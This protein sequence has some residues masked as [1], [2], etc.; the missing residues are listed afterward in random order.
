MKKMIFIKFG[1]S[2]ITDKNQEEKVNLDSIDNLSKQVSEILNKEKDIK[3]MIGNG[4]GS[5]GHM[6]VERYK[7]NNGVKTSVQ[8]LGVTKVQELVARLNQMVV[9]SLT[10]HN[11]P[12][13]SIKPSSIITT[14]DKKIHNLPMDPLINYLNEKDIKIDK[15]IFCGSTK[16]VL[17]LNGNTIS[18][19]TKKSF[20]NIKNVFFENRY[21]DVTGSMKKKVETA[22]RIT[23]FGIKSYIIDI[24]SLSSCVLDNKFFGT[25]IK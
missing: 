14:S 21:A 3:I 18:E 5:F 20:P 25:V 22:L 12:A 10:K 9:K 15:I 7:L 24:A 8:K 13:V 19:I 23:E 4:A 16:G 17:D 6:Q 2:I 11:L 1:G